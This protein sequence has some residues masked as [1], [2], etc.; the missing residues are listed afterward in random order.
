W[1]PEPGGWWSAGRRDRWTTPTFVSGQPVHPGEGERGAADRPAHGCE[2]RWVS[3]WS[4]G[5]RDGS[6]G[7]SIR[8]DTPSLRQR[9]GLLSR[10]SRSAK[11]GSMPG[12]TTL[13][14]AQPE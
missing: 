12:T 9:R 11:L 8:P 13:A 5:D 7:R 2:T 1:A 4:D 6:N 10:T 14:V 3:D